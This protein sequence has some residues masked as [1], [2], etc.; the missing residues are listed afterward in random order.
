MAFIEHAFA[1]VTSPGGRKLIADQNQGYVPLT[2]AG[3]DACCVGDGTAF[4]GIV[5]GFTLM[6][7]APPAD[8]PPVK[9]PRV[10]MA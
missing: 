10:L 4:G 2:R 8:G 6:R 1:T 3:L 7:G 5:S 9:K